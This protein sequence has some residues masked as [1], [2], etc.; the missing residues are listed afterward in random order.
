MQT[1][2]EGLGKL[3]RPHVPPPGF[4]IAVAACCIAS[5]SA[6]VGASVG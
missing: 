1:A 2:P 3:H 6:A 4:K 5:Q